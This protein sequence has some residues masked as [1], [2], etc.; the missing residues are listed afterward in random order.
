MRIGTAGWSI[1]LDAAPSFPGQGHHLARYA[2]ILGCAEINSSF[3]RSHRVEVYQRWADQTPQDFRFAVKVPRTITH[4]GRLRRAR[5]PLLRFLAEVAGLGDRLAVLLV[6]LPPSFAFEVRPTR[7]FFALLREL[8]EGAVV[9]E[10][11]HPSWFTPAADR[12]LFACGVGRAAADPACCPP[13]REPGGW[14]GVEGDGR[15]AVI[16][17]RW[18]GSPRMYWS[19]YDLAWVQARADKVEQWPVGADCWCIFDNT[20]GGGAIW[21]ALELRARLETG[22]SG[23]R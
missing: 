3:Y 4:D 7:R 1:P 8:F 11:R 15:G 12:A 23:S 13:A 20:G 10:P 9:C 6:Q 19:R 17:Y 5:E 21:N 16:Y 22:T 18:H 2:R 14:L